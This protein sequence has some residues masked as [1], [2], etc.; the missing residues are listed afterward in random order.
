MMNIH[1]CII[2]ISPPKT[3]PRFKA[4]SA[5][6]SSLKSRSKSGPELGSKIEEKPVFLPSSGSGIPID[7]KRTR[8]LNSQKCPD[9]QELPYSKALT[10]CGHLFCDIC[11]LEYQKGQECPLCRTVISGKL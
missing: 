6:K 7:S 1:A 3:M 10:P 9:C 2:L 11:I 4:N 8:K 5:T